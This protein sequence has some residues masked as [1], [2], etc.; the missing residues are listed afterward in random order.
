MSKVITNLYYNNLFKKELVIAKGTKIVH[1]KHNHDINIQLYNHLM[2]NDEINRDT[3]TEIGVRVI[4]RKVKKI[5]D[6]GKFFLEDVGNG[7]YYIIK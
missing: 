7:K 5:N 3:M 6:G 1:N 2:N 4:D